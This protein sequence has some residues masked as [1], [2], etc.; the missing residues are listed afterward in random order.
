[1]EQEQSH[2]AEP[3]ILFSCVCVCD[4]LIPH[5]SVLHSLQSTRKFEKSLLAVANVQRGLNLNHTTSEF[6]TLIG[7]KVYFLI[8]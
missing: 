5:P 3:S 8:H 1:M 6:F 4:T 2:N 7:Q